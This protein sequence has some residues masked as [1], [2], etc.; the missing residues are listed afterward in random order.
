[1]VLADENYTVE[2]EGVIKEIASQLNI[3]DEQVTAIL[4]YVQEVLWQ[5]GPG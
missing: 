4:K 5:R 3:S 1:M 2:E